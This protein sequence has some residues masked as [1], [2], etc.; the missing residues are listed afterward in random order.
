MKYLH[1]E[2]AKTVMLLATEGLHPG[3]KG[4]RFHLAGTDRSVTPMPQPR[5]RRLGD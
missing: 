1:E 5:G 2:L 4:V 3:T